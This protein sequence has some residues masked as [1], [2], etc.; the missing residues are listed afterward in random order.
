MHGTRRP[1]QFPR[2]QSCSAHAH[3]HRVIH[4][5]KLTRQI[6]CITVINDAIKLETYD[7]LSFNEASQLQSEIVP[8]CIILSLAFCNCK[9][10]F[11]SRPSYFYIIFPLSYDPLLSKS[12]SSLSFSCS[13]TLK[14]TVKGQRLVQQTDCFTC[15]GFYTGAIKFIC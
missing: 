15:L 3:A 12:L 14:Y 13:A 10:L 6:K 8:A 7:T 1:F 9:S 2:P 11:C 5:H 4:L